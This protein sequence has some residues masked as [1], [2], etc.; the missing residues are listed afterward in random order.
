M[1]SSSENSN[2]LWSHFSILLLLL[3]CKAIGKPLND[4][5]V[6][7][8]ITICKTSLVLGICYSNKVTCLFETEYKSSHAVA[9]S[10]SSKLELSKFWLFVF[11]KWSKLCHIVFWIKI[12]S[13]YWST[14]KMVK[15]IVSKKKNYLTTF[16]M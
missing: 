1:A 13:Y 16:Q 2:L 10:R 3:Y 7:R 15:I 8:N 6:V 12:M 4:E 14:K 5:W 11:N 9:G